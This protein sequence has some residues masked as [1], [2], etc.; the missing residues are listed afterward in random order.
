MKYVCIII[1]FQVLII[2]ACSN[3]A[4]QRFDN[5]AFSN[6]NEDGTPALVN[7]RSFQN[8]DKT[9]GFTII[10]NNVPFR[11]YN[12]IP[13]KKNDAGFSSKQEAEQVAEIFVKQIKKGIQSPVLTRAMI[14]SMQIKTG[15]DM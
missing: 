9:W 14:D 13:Y 5:A 12:T 4:S 15:N 3:K 6:V 2:T 10:I 11:N 1:I 8:A 7:F